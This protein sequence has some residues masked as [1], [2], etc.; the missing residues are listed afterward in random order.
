MLDGSQ[1]TPI[2]HQRHVGG[3]NP[4]KSV[5]DRFLNEQNRLDDNDDLDFDMY[6]TNLQ[7]R[8][9][10]LQADQSFDFTDVL[11]ESLPSMVQIHSP[12]KRPPVSQVHHA[13]ALLPTARSIVV[14]PRIQ[15]LLGMS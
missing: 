15:S 4:P 8:T 5:D 3:D 11:E 10:D 2:F 14:D 7:L 13:P 12:V 9:N 6:T 1:N